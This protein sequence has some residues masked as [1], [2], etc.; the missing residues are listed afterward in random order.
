MSHLRHK[1]ELEAQI[2][3]AT[4]MLHEGFVFTFGCILKKKAQ[5]KS[6]WQPR[7]RRC[8]LTSLAAS[9]SGS[10]RNELELLWRFQQAKHSPPVSC[11]QCKGTGKV[12]CPWCHSTG[13]M[14]LGDILL[15]SLDGSTN[16][17]NCEDGEIRC[18]KCQGS[19]R[20][21]AWLQDIE[22]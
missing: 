2:S 21:A 13:V 22:L 1:T 16:C 19:G 17:L 18:R 6:C 4:G 10:E 8:L 11:R 3:R 9:L 20:V 7:F 14:T 5:G 15:C 12:E